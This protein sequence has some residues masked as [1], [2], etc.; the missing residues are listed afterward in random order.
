M[1]NLLYQLGRE[2]LDPVVETGVQED[3][4]AGVPMAVPLEAD[5]HRAFE[6]EEVEVEVAIDPGSLLEEMEE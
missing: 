4:A 6:T 1:P 2:V 3:M 5:F